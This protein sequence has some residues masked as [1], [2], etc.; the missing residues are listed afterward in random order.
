MPG[1]IISITIPDST[2]RM[3]KVDFGGIMKDICVEWLDVSVGNYI[4]AHA[5][6]ALCQIDETEAQLTLDAFDE[7]IK[8]LDESMSLPE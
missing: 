1:R 7:I 2:L 6:V 4:L 3:A 8:Q 5:G